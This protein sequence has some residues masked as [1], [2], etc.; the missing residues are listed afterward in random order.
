MRNRKDKLKKWYR[1]ENG[2]P[3]MDENG[4]FFSEEIENA[5][6]DEPDYE[7][8]KSIIRYALNKGYP[9]FVF[10]T[11][12]LSAAEL[13]LILDICYETEGMRGTD[14]AEVWKMSRS[15]LN[16]DQLRIVLTAYKTRFNIIDHLHNARNYSPRVLWWLTF[17]H[18]ACRA[19]MCKLL[20]NGMGEEEFIQKVMELYK[21]RGKKKYI[22]QSLLKL[23]FYRN[24]RARFE[25]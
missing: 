8:W 15:E 10:C 1:D 24:E 18:C 23:A 2:N 11:T 20:N 22:T 4:M 12:M 25:E 14:P 13:R 19:N 7:E 17:A 16:Y 9:D 3:F 5:R 21:K 6:A